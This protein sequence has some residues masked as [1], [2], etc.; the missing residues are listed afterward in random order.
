MLI[1]IF[2]KRG[3]GKTTFIRGQLEEMPGP[4]VVIDVLGNFKNEDFIETDKVSDAVAMVYDYANNPKNS[5]GTPKEKIFVV[6]SQDPDMAVEYLG[7]A[8]WHVGGGTLVLD[9]VDMITYSKGSVIDQIVRYGR[10]KNVGLIT[11]CRRPA[12]LHKNFTAGANKIYV[13]NT[14]EP[15]DIDYY[16]RTILG[17]KAQ[18]LR[19]MPEHTGILIDY[20]RK[21]ICDFK[22]DENGKLFIMNA[23]PFHTNQIS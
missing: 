15:N 11:G 3:S 10:N 1:T 22:V 19:N 17:T 16:E 7:A 14:Q 9:E 2:G 20:D 6:T 4:V 13:Y 21:E 23:V 8:L 18:N 5:D 12:E